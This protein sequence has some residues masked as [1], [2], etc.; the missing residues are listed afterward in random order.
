M[1]TVNGTF[2]KY[3]CGY[4]IYE[5]QIVLINRPLKNNQSLHCQRI[6]QI[7]CK[8]ILSRINMVL[9]IQKFRKLEDFNMVVKLENLK[10]IRI[11]SQVMMKIVFKKN[12]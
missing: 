7:Q 3:G 8:M 1:A 9:I 12:F 4:Q 5:Q 10:M 6:F 11:M 2:Y